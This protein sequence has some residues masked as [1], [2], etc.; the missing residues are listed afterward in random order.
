[1][2]DK[3]V[4]VKIGDDIEWPAEW[5]VDGSPQNLDDFDVRCQVRS[6]N[7]MLAFE[8]DVTPLDQ[9]THRGKFTLSAPS[10]VT[11]TLRHDVYDCDIMYRNLDSG[12]VETSR[13]ILIEFV[14]RVT[15]GT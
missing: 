11:A 13:T 9:E 12:Q 4:T 7:G 10:S 1:M 2:S 6:T 14:N 3:M 15:R 8:F 5:I